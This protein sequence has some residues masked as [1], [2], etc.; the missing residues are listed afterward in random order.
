M[1]KDLYLNERY[2]RQIILNGFGEEG[3]KSLQRLSVLVVGAGG[4][5]CPALQYLVA[6]GVGK[7]GIADDDIVS[8]HNLHRQ[9]LYTTEDIGHLKTNVAALRLHQ[10][11]P[12]VLIETYPFRITNK[13][14]L[15]IIISYNIVLDATDN[16][17]TRYLIND[18]CVLLR[19]PLVY[20]AISK[21]EGQVALFNA[22]ERKINYR[23]LFPK[24]STNGSILNCSETGVIGVLPGIIG[25][26]QA[27]EVIKLATGI[28]E[29]L[30]NQLFTYNALT[31]ES[32]VFALTSKKET[33]EHLPKSRAAFEEM[34]YDWFCESKDMIADEVEIFKFNQFIG[35]HNVAIID[36]REKGEAPEVLEFSHKHIPLSIFEMNMV[37]I[38]EDTVVLF[39]QSG[40]RSKEA[41]S[42]LSK[43]FGNS[44]RIYSLQG[45]ILNWIRNGKQK[46]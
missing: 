19:K 27:S 13:N 4:L 36:V 18:A 34:N 5:G 26:V 7:I 3:Q 8:L 20:G 10:M 31:N 24:P 12:D 33:T 32:F 11:N 35:D 37:S 38:K 40:K 46:A 43:K 41:A 44:K 1:N 29:P 6:A 28:G 14:A 9:V 17:A 22:D 16:F 42:L 2:Q 45:G 21:F 30:I 23:D 15:D 39:C 25:T